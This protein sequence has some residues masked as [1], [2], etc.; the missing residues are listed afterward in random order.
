ML[1]FLVDVMVI[2]NNYIY[3]LILSFVKEEVVEGSGGWGVGCCE[4]E[5]DSCYR[6]F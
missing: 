4:G 2:D 1:K 6:I 3:V 5:S